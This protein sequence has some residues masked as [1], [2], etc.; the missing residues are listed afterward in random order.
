MQHLE[1]HHTNSWWAL[2]LR[3]AQLVAKDHSLL[4]TLLIAPL[5]YAFFYGSI[6]SNKAEEQV[7]ID[8][9][10]NDQT[11][12]SHTYIQELRNTQMV[13]IRALVPFETA[14]E[15]MYKGITQ[16]YLLIEKGLEKKVMSLQ[17][18]KVVLVLNAAR[19][20]PSSDL[21]QNIT[22]VTLTVGAGVR[23]QYNQKQ[24]MSSDISMREVAPVSVDYHPLFNP[25][26]NYGTFLIP[27]LLALILQQ[28]LLIG[29]S[30][31]VA[32]E[33]QHRRIK[34]WINTANGNVSTAIWGKGLFYFILFGI[35]GYF[36]MNVNYRV[37][38]FSVLGNGLELGAM[39]LLFILTLIP[40][41]IFIGSLFRSQLLCTQVMAFSTY[42]VFL[43]TGY[44]W[45]LQELPAPLQVISALLP[46][47]P[48]IN[49]YTAIVQQGAG[50]N[51]RLPSLVHLCALWVMYSFVCIWWL[52]R[53]R[54]RDSPVKLAVGA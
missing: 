5:L 7:P 45:P 49:L 3:E 46:T 38:G 29:L 25:G 23:L 21:L 37:L 24:G 20:L 40:M 50:I 35:Y 39:I 11:S 30:G 6:Y 52:R 27:G 16:G 26:S 22:T 47:T 13:Q 32:A 17:G 31:G 8:I 51:D 43:V 18:S 1:H 48:F 4:L 19:F 53:I 41:G 42:P 54:E 14:Q 10:D 9:V 2:L 36:F 33:R 34:D 15:N 12:L 28:T 44:T